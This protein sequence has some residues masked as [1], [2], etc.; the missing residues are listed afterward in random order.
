MDSGDPPD[1]TPVDDHGPAEPPSP[2]AMDWMQLLAD[3]TSGDPRR[4][5]PAADAF[6]GVI[7]RT[8]AARGAYARRQSWDDISQ[9]VLTKMLE[10]ASTIRDPQAWLR[11][12]TVNTYIDSVRRQ[13][14]Q[15]T[16][17]DHLLHSAPWLLPHS[18]PLVDESVAKKEEAQ[19]LQEGLDKLSL[20][21]RSLVR[22]VYPNEPERE[23][24][25]RDEIALQLGISRSDVQNRLRRALSLLRGHIK[26]GRVLRKFRKSPRRKWHRWPS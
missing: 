11:R 15:I 23:L 26:R 22:A 5:G 4:E 18:P 1:D 16:H 2:W 7:T 8:L 10:N 13:T 21:H 24:D 3:F 6:I 20:A 17:A 25:T 19:D 14:T 9:N 12:T